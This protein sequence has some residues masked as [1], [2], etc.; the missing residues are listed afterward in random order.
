MVASGKTKWTNGSRSLNGRG[1]GAGTGPGP[2]VVRS[3]GVARR[4]DSINYPHN[5]ERRSP[6]T[7]N[8]LRF[9]QTTK[10]R[11]KFIIY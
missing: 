4:R 6:T 9:L 8:A 10:N 2:A 5:Y 1:K 7:D 3:N 11:S